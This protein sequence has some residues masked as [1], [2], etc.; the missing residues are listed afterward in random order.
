MNLNEITIK[1]N[2]LYK[3]YSFP[4]TGNL[5]TAELFFISFME[6]FIGQSVTYCVDKFPQLVNPNIDHV[7]LNRQRRRRGFRKHS[8]PDSQEWSEGG[9]YL[10]VK[11]IV[12]IF[13]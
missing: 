11:N 10:T 8:S 3:L 12:K 13:K 1:I 5:K 4:D 9:W 6:H 2:L 7:K